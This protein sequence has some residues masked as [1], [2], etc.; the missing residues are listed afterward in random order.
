MNELTIFNYENNE[1]RTVV[2]DDE[3]WFVGKD[4]AEILGYKLPQKAITDLVDKEDVK[5]LMY[6]AFSETEKAGLWGANDFSNKNLINE[7]GLYSLIISSKLE[8]AK[9]FKR[10]VTSEVL[11]SIR[12]NGMYAIDELLDNPDLLIQTAV[13]LKEERTK[14]LIAEAKVA[15][16]EPKADYVDKILKC[17]GT[18]ATTQV[19]FDYGMSARQFNKLLHELGIQYK[20]NGQWILY[21]KHQRKGYVKTKTYERDGKVFLSTHWTQ[22]GR[23]FLYEELK[24][25]GHCPNEHLEV[26]VDE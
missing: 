16:Y 22:K 19:A 26:D 10:W 6:K 15:E 14:R 21:T 1:V 20:V 12:K 18:M 5:T 4:V 3:V 9:K 7:S 8:G 25:A 23:L 13:K 24:K 11:P 17:Q 2:I